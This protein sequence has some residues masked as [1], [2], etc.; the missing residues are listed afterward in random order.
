MSEQ[1]QWWEGGNATFERQLLRM[2]LARDAKHE[3]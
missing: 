1:A 3:E 2:Q